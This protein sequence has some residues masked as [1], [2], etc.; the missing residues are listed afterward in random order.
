[1]LKLFDLK[2]KKDEGAD[3]APAGAA[4]KVTAAQLRVQKDHNE[5]TWPHGFE[6]ILHNGVD[7]LMNFKVAYKPADGYWKGGKFF[8]DF[9]FSDAYPH[10]PPSVKCETNI[11]HPNIDTEGNICLNILREDWNPVLNLQAIAFGLV[12]IFQDPGVEDPLNKEAAEVF[13]RDIKRFER[14]VKQS[15][16][17]G[18]V[19][20]IRYTSACA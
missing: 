18:N 2:K 16:S 4:A 14:N 9:K 13:R 11:Y 6:L 12:L 17:G 8:F 1:M 5:V 3:A 20:G 15:I 10:K 19:D 7:D